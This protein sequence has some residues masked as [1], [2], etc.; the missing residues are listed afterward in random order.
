MVQKSHFIFYDTLQKTTKKVKI[1][2]TLSNISSISQA[3][4][5]N[6]LIFL[7]NL[8][9]FFVIDVSLLVSFIFKRFRYAEAR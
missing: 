9:L 3:D 1:F 8:I 5:M 7:K 2:E 6:D 4:I